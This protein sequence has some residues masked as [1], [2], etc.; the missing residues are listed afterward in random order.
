MN[1]KQLQV[2]QE[3]AKCG[4]FTAAARTLGVSQPAVSMQVKAFQDSLGITLYRTDGKHLVLTEAGR[5]LADYA[6]RI[7]QLATE[8]ER[9]LAALRDLQSDNLRISTTKT[10][11]TDRHILSAPHNGCVQIPSSGSEYP[12]RDG[13]NGMG[14]RRRAYAR[15]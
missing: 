11:A 8:A 4:S 3:V 12:A 13:D 7:F 1:L 6:D 2:F 5:L 14:H 9:Q 15:E 10:I